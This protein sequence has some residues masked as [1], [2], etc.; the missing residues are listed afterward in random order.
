MSYNHTSEDDDDAI[1]YIHPVF[2]LRRTDYSMAL[3]IYSATLLVK[4]VG[5][6]NFELSMCAI[7]STL[8]PEILPPATHGT[9]H[10]S[11]NTNTPCPLPP[12][13]YLYC[14]TTDCFNGAAVLSM[15][16]VF[17]LGCHV[18]S[19]SFLGPHCAFV[20]PE[21]VFLLDLRSAASR[22]KSTEMLNRAADAENSDRGMNRM[23]KGV[24]FDRTKMKIKLQ[25]GQALQEVD[26]I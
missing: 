4:D 17:N 5:D 11:T 26:L 25:V 3:S 15:H 10:T 21:G 14:G 13:L 23:E 19:C 16:P 9:R 2:A 18:S 1:K 20:A 8:V 12:Q 22:A 6:G 7:G 24:A